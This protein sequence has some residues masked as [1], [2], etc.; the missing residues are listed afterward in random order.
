MVVTSKCGKLPKVILQIICG[1][2]NYWLNLN[3]LKKNLNKGIDKLIKKIT[4]K[5]EIFTVFL[6]AAKHFSQLKCESVDHHFTTLKSNITL[7]LSLSR[8]HTLTLALPL[9]PSYRHTPGITL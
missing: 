4:V 8:F 7:S 9:S 6:F 1:L 3:I 5:V 2:T